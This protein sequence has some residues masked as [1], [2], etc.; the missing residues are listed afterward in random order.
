[1]NIRTT[2]A[3][4]VLGLASTVA[5]AQTAPA[6]PATP[7]AA[8]KPAAAA[9]AKKAAAS[10]TKQCKTGYTLVKGKCEKAKTQG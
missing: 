3:T 9:P 2:L 8:A 10:T 6:A 1:M 7:A 5:M 4:L